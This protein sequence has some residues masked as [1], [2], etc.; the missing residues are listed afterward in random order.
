MG[1]DLYALKLS[2]SFNQTE[3]D[4]IIKKDFILSQKW[5]QSSIYANDLCLIQHKMTLEEFLNKYSEVNEYIIDLFLN[6]DLMKEFNDQIGLTELQSEWEN[7]VND[8]NTSSPIIN[9]Y[10]KHS[11]NT[12]HWNDVK[13]TINK[14]KII[15]KYGS[16]ILKD[17][18]LSDLLK[19]QIL[20]PHDVPEAISRILSRK[21]LDEKD[22]RIVRFIKMFPNHIFAFL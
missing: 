2:K 17:D 11:E 10:F 20:F 16:I 13:I 18:S 5:E 8:G 19:N 9:Y 3:L 21:D 6:Q 12:V 14:K 1:L 7:E 22:L 4:T 15:N